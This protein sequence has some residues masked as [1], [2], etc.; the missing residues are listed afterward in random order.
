MPKNG[1]LRNDS[2][3]WN[4]N[5][6]QTIILVPPSNIM[7]GSWWPS[8]G[9][10]GG[11]FKVTLSSGDPAGTAA[12]TKTPQ[13]VTGSWYDP[14]YSGSGFTIFMAEQGLVALYFGWDSSGNRLW[15]ESDIG[16]AQITPGAVYNLNMNQT[17]GGNF[18][19]PASPGTLA[20]WGTLQINFL[21]CHSAAAGLTSQDGKNVVVLNLQKLVGVGALVP[22]C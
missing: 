19:T 18:L 16:P 5:G 4:A 3:P 8:S 13:S 11:T 1:A 2:N 20:V 14:A 6:G 22:G 15:L 21:T 9:S 10:S 7:G 12:L 17:S